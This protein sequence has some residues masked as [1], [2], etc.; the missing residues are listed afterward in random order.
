MEFLQGYKDDSSY[1]LTSQN[2]RGNS[3]FENE[4]QECRSL[5]V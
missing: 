1:S 4:N 5:N 3:M 2:F